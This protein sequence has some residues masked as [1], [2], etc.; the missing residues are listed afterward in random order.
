MGDLKG[1][2]FLEEESF[3]SVG[4]ERFRR[5]SNRMEEGA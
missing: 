2:G 4:V 1:C 5:V 3:F